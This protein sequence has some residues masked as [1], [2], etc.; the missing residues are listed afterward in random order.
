MHYESTII[1]KYFAIPESKYTTFIQ[2]DIIKYSHVLLWHFL[3]SIT[4]K[5]DYLYGHD[6]F[7][8]T[9]TFM[10]I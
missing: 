7:A 8:K 2:G 3:K 1:Q 10:P 5:K 9:T 4:E 6:I